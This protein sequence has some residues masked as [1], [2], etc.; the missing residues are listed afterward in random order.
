MRDPDTCEVT[1]KVPSSAKAMPAGPEIASF[2]S[3]RPRWL[4]APAATPTKWPLGA[5]RSTWVRVGVRVG[6]RARAG[7]RA[8][9]RGRARGRARNGGRVRVRVRVRVRGWV[10]VWA[11]A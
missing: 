10:R 11:W 9:A 8:R 7:G 5:K 1:K 6:A 2:P 4:V 3:R